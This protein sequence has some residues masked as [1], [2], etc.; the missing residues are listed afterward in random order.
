LLKVILK[1]NKS[2][3]IKITQPW[4]E[5]TSAA[6]NKHGRHMPFLFLIGQFLKM[7]FSVTA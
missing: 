2:N 5:K 3:Q 7:F 6:V 1:H 4:M